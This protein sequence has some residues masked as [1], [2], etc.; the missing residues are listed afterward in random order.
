MVI[1]EVAAVIAE[2][3]VVIA[4]VAVVI[5]EVVAVIAEVAA[6]ITAAVEIITDVV[7]EPIPI[8]AATS[9]APC[10]QFAPTVAMTSHVKKPSFAWRC[11]M[12]TGNTRAYLLLRRSKIHIYLARCCGHNIASFQ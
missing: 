9:T 12:R 3:A 10:Q 5:A 6:V 7:W 4:E 2:V 11:R 1:A 8:L